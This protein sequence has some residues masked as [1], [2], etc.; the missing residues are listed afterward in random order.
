[1]TRAACW[2]LTC[3]LLLATTS[4]AESP[5]VVLIVA[6]DLSA[7]IGAFGDTVALTPNIDRLADE[8]VRYP[9][10]F[11][12][13]GVCAPSRAA[14]ITG[15]HQI[16]I[17]AQHMRASSRPDGAYLTV[18]P[19]HVKAFP[20]RLRAVGYYTLVNHKL[21]YQF[22]GPLSGGPFTIWD[23]QGN[24]ATWADRPEGAPFFAM[25]NLMETHE[26]GL[27]PP[28][29]TWP[30]SGMHLVMQLARAWQFGLADGEL[31]TPPDSLVLPP[32]Y[33]DTP[34]VRRDLAQH[35]DNI[36]TMD[37]HVGSILDRLRLDGLL[38]STIVVWTTDHGDGL[39]RAKREVYDSGIRVPMII[40][41]PADLRPDGAE[42]GTFDARL[43]SFVDLA[44]TILDWA[45]APVPE[46]LHGR[47]LADLDAPPRR[48]VYASRDRIDEIPDRQRAVRDTRFKYIRSWHPEQ[49]GGHAL[50]FRDNIAMMQELH[51]LRASGELDE[52]QSRWFEPPGSE[53]LFDLENDPHELH[54]VLH[55]PTYRA[56][57]ERMRATLAAWLER[58]EDW[59]ELPEDEMVAR[60][61]PN[62][63]QP[64]TA[65][66]QFKTSDMTV[67]ITSPTD[68]ASI[69]YRVGAGTW[70]LYTGPVPKPEDARIDA[71]AIRYGWEESSVSSYR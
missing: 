28:L 7:R 62:G 15:L 30:S 3:S 53:R 61:W 51:A 26:S 24:D 5:N 17:G 29:G 69:G 65:A 2:I 1:M 64:V 67:R 70:R 35:Y 54:D 6:E 10:A 42:P 71:K 27:F 21:D 41:W 68:G 66:P 19:P 45:G 12:T 18:P 23:A 48:Y 9:N 40:R 8:G 11:T 43:V 39:P 63:A 57:A 25:F 32:Y 36:A 16:S 22:S 55:D 46:T 38:E 56:D 14:L 33:P 20:E 44:P 59:S 52:A 50:A 13:A 58:V 31:L 60:F 47:S 37:T 49:V 4:G 34:T